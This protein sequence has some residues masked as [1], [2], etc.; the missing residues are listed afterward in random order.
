MSH[1]VNRTS[2]LFLMIRSGLT[3]LRRRNSPTSPSRSAP[4][5]KMSTSGRSFNASI[6][7]FRYGKWPFASHWK[8]KLRI[9]RRRLPASRFS[10]A[11]YS[12]NAPGWSKTYFIFSRI[13]IRK[14][15]FRRSS[16]GSFGNRPGKHQLFPVLVPAAPP[17]FSARKT[18]RDLR[19]AGS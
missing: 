11:K 17:D 1:S 13:P 2:E 9:P 3:P 10:R 4:V 16:S 18:T 6:Y 7:G 8:R 12:G 19:R 5:R 15:A 14:S